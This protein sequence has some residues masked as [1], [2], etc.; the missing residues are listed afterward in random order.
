MSR[1]S[2]QT[3]PE[4]ILKVTRR[5]MSKRGY[6]KVS[7]RD[8][9]AELGISQ[10]NLTYYYKTKAALIEAAI[11][12]KHEKRPDLKP[13]S[14]LGEFDALLEE[15]QKLQKEHL[16]YFRQ[17]S[18]L[19]VISENVKKKQIKVFQDIKRICRKT[20][21]NL[22]HAGLM[23][24]ESHKGQYKMLIQIIRFISAHWYEQDVLNESLGLETPSARIAIW[25]TLFPHLTDKGKK[26]YL[27]QIR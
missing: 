11:M 27:E 6:E 2:K 1:G 15:I 19:S 26:I 20:F 10:G 5:L 17:Y 14:S 18:Q 23:K 21:G 9:A 24:E 8:I 7:L 22:C 25:E 12:D 4:A 3:T 16:Y 13:V